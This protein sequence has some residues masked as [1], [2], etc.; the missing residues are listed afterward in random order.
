[1]LIVSTMNPMISNAIF[2]GIGCLIGKMISKL[3]IAIFERN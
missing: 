2:F 1:M 3:I